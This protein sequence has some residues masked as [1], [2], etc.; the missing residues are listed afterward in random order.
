[1]SNLGWMNHT[2]R[3]FVAALVLVAASGR[4]ALAP[5]DVATGKGSV[6]IGLLAPASGPLAGD[7]GDV[8]AGLRYYLATHGDKLGG[9]S[10]EIRTGDEGATPEAAIATTHQLVEQDAVDVIVGVLNS[11]NAY[12]LAP[13]IDAQKK[14]LLI[15]GAGAD[16][17][18]QTQAQKT[19]FRVAHTSSQDVMPLGEYVCHR[20]HLR[21]AALVAADYA[22]GV[23]AAGGFARGYTDSGCRVL[24][25]QY[26]PRGSDW[27]SAVDKIDKRAQVVFAAVGAGDSV[28]FVSAYRAGGPKIELTGDGDLTDERS[29]PQERERALG[30]TT[31]CHYSAVVNNRDNVAFRLGYESLT[32]HTVSLF[33]ENGYVAAQTLAAALDKQPP[34][35]VK[36]DALLAALRGVQLN[37][38]RGPVHFDKFQQI[39]NPV[40]IRR[41]R[42]VGGR[43][44]NEVIDTY[45]D[46]SQFWQYDPQR[47]LALPPYSKLK[48]TWARP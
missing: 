25:E 19:I 3:A 41:V 35:A 10:I 23:E 11:S 2:A 20:M 45:P 37:A 46:V 42:Q 4:P 38:P 8:E 44:R 31:G 33:V 22:Y 39:V 48:G 18:T 6:R 28:A 27:T 29:L 1:V 36:I 17:L 12:A 40:Y 32:G 9:F 34:G 16:E 43:F 21:T 7:G 47:Y 14:L 5:A 26:G 30:I 13:Y 24:Q 15:A